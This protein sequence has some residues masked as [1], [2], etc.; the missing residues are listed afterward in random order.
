MGADRVLENKIEISLIARTETH[1]I[2]IRFFR[3]G[4]PIFHD[5]AKIYEVHLL[6]ENRTTLT[7]KNRIREF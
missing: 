3:Y 1:A 6:S 7:E 4:K 5:A 2:S